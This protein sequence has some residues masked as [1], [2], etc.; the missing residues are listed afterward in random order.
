MEKAMQN[1]LEE[2]LDPK[3]D[4]TNKKNNFPFTNIIKSKLFKKSSSL[5]ALSHSNIIKNPDPNFY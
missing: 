3:T 1:N 5:F 2:S 4:L